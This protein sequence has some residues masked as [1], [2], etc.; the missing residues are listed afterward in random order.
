MGGGNDRGPGRK[1]SKTIIVPNEYRPTIRPQDLERL[2]SHW[3]KETGCEVLYVMR[4]RILVKFDIFGSGAPLEHAIRIINKWIQG[5]NTRSS[6][7]SQWAKTPAFDP[8]QWYYDK[9][10]A[11]EAERK[12]R[13]KG[14]MP[15]GLVPP[16]QVRMLFEPP[17]PRYGAAQML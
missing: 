16:C 5:A 4:S 2:T 1:P 12:E 10:N 8:Y 15:N 14:P 6:A 9:I 13:F 11:M 3:H 7:S 17:R